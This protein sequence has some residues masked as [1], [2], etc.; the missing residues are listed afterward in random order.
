MNI[1]KQWTHTILKWCPSFNPHSRHLFVQQMFLNAPLLYT[2][3]HTHTPLF[4]LAV[5]WFDEVVNWQFIYPRTQNGVT[6]F[7]NISSFSL[8]TNAEN[9]Y[10][11]LLV[12][13][14]QESRYF[15]HS[16]LSFFFS[17]YFIFYL[18]KMMTRPPPHLRSVFVILYVHFFYACTH[19]YT[20]TNT[21]HA[22]K[23]KQE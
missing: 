21:T 1:T 22:K 14:L 9:S 19:T 4:S 6:L 11:P 13:W 16:S 17:F 12:W 23:N 15:I 8:N 18:K 20:H 2:H 10:S 5:W 3:T 7:F